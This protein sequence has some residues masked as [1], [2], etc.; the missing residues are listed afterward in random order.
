M[1]D[2]STMTPAAGLAKRVVNL[3]ELFGGDDGAIALNIS[4]NDLAALLGTS[5]QTVNRILRD[6]EERGWIALRYKRMR[7]V[8]PDSLRSVQLGKAG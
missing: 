7:I 3:A 8:R 4:Q 5:R 6:S 2:A 1:L